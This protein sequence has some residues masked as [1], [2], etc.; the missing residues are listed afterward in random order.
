MGLLTYLNRYKIQSFSLQNGSLKSS[1]LTTFRFEE[2]E[3][4]FQ[5]KRVGTNN[6]SSVHKRA[7][8]GSHLERILNTRN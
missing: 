8:T 3:K 6:T 5:Y 7:T 4:C 2:T 1:N